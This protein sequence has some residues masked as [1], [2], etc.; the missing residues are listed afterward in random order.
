MLGIIIN[1]VHSDFGYRPPNRKNFCKRKK[2]WCW[3][4][5]YHTLI[6]KCTKK[7]VDN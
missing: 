3:F 1:Y 5:P 4:R 2:N 7:E 6:G